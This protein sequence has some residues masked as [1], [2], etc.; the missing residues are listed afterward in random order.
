M[1]EDLKYLLDYKNGKIQK[2]LGIG[3]YLDE[4]L[5]F[6]RGQLNIILGHDNV[7]KSYWINY[8]FLNLA[9]KH[10]LK[11]AIYSGENKKANIF[12]DF[13][14]MYCG[15]KFKE[16]PE[17]VIVESYKHLEQ[18]F[19]FVPN[20]RLYKPN[21]LFSIFEAAKCDAALID[22]FTALDRDMTYDGNYKFLNAARELVNYTGITLYINTH[23]TSES[24]RAGNMYH[25]GHDWSGH[26]KA[27]L[28]DHIE[29]GKAFL[30]RCDDMLVIHR[31]V[32]HETMKFTTMINVEKVKDVDTGGKHTNLDE[33]ILFDFNNGIGFTVR[34][35]DSLA[36][37]RPK[38]QKSNSF[39]TKIQQGE[40]MSTSEKIRLGMFNDKLF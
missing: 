7:G 8:Y 32:K 31:L 38:F 26:I 5:V 12:R 27:P 22:P 20:D 39:P 30:N 14:Q 1:N 9:L 6:K 2:G 21:D 25:A 17:T 3:N 28:K 4:H 18:F 33:P 24:G 16:I 15:M 36:A 35:I 19:T 23:P 29:G 11:F 37:E 40:L 10:G 13:I 34:G